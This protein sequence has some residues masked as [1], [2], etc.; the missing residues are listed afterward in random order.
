MCL[1]SV[2]QINPELFV[3]P[4]FFK[5]VGNSFQHSVKFPWS[6]T[7]SKSFAIAGY[8]RLWY[9]WA[10]LAIYSTCP[11]AERLPSLR[12][13]WD[14]LAPYLAIFVHFRAISEPISAFW[15]LVWAKWGTG[16]TRRQRGF[17]VPVQPCD[18]LV[19]P[20]V[21]IV[22]QPGSERFRYH[23]C[24]SWLSLPP[25]GVNVISHKMIAPGV[26]RSVGL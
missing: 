15:R 13:G 6:Q 17:F 10:G 2:Q 7:L 8:E 14:S 16:L 19:K 18:K 3:L 12:L 1:R 24:L 5:C 21:N 23:L 9:V 20:G 11:R 4:V 25:G 22:S 26:Y